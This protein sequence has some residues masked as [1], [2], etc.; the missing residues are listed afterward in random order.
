MTEF[1][2]QLMALGY[3]KLTKKKG[4][5]NNS[6]ED[7]SKL[8]VSL[9][10]D[11]PDHSKID[12]KRAEYRLRRAELDHIAA[13]FAGF[14]GREKI[15]SIADSSLLR[16]IKLIE[17]IGDREHRIVTIDVRFGK[18][19][20][21]GN[22]AVKKK[23]ILPHTTSTC[24]QKQSVDEFI[25]TEKITLNKGCV[26]NKEM[27]ID[28]ATGSRNLHL[29]SSIRQQICESSANTTELVM[30]IDFGTSNTKL[31][32][33]EQGTGR[34]W[35]IPFSQEGT[36]KYLLSSHI[37][38]S[39]NEYSLK[40]Q[41]QD[42]L[43]NLKLPLVLGAYDQ[44]SLINIVAFLVLVIKHSREWFLVNA[45]DSFSG[46]SFEWLYHIGMP[47]SNLED[48]ALRMTYKKLLGCAV[49]ISIED[50]NILSKDS[51]ESKLDMINNGVVDRYSA[52]D[53]IGVFSELQSQLEGYVRSDSW[54]NKK[55][56][57]LLIDV[58]G[59]TVDVAIVNVTDN[60][61]G[62][63]NYNCLKSVVAPMGAKL[64]HQ[65]RLKWIHNNIS[66]GEGFLENLVRDLDLAVAREDRIVVL[67]DMVREYIS[68]AVWPDRGVDEIFYEEF[69]ELVFDKI[70]YFVKQ[71]MDTEP[72]QWMDLQVVLCGGGALHCFYNKILNYKNFRPVYMLKPSSLIGSDLH[73][74]EYHR[75]S[76]AY[77][78]SFGDQGS[79]VPSSDIGEMKRQPMHGGEGW[80]SSYIDQP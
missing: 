36:D 54:S 14:N 25:G 5:G 80:R 72:N 19:Q 17:T 21:L 57:F 64:L 16:F 38:Y 2:K 9:K 32:I 67:P 45:A 71:K 37:Y 51:V 42:R 75:L 12:K 65:I 8:A 69:R 39:N 20:I 46:F 3:N 52:G 79:H 15:S 26:V 77:G 62:L 40:G 49:D 44:T 78:L 29:Y 59:G 66:S 60:Q 63:K 47:A 34:S 1:E 70:I 73:E 43:G 41:E 61:S 22:I 28:R 74:D 56:K 27:L 10:K 6:S 50:S 33:Q 30:G 35:A 7:A 4:A 58:G 18:P 48:Q 76:V 23:G 55:I 24:D 68:D 31:I 11:V 53:S 13:S